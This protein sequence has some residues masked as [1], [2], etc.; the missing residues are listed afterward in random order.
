MLLR[1]L[2]VRMANWILVFVSLLAFLADGWQLLSID[3]E[4]CRSQD[5][6][7]VHLELA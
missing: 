1:A 3:K 6:S 5:P 7:V 4:F 2:Y